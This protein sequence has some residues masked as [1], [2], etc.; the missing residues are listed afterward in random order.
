MWTNSVPLFKSLVNVMF[1]SLFLHG[2]LKLYPGRRGIDFTVR[3]RG[4]NP[5]DSLII[6]KLVRSP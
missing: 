6:Q 5:K 3:L 2:D 1:L 4:S